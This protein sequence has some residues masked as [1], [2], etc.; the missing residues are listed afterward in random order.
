MS[1]RSSSCPIIYPNFTVRSPLL[2]L[3][4]T[5]VRVLMHNAQCSGSS[6]ASCPRRWRLRFRSR[7]KHSLRGSKNFIS[8]RRQSTMCAAIRQL[9]AI[10]TMKRKFGGSKQRMIIS[11]LNSTT[12]NWPSARCPPRN[13]DAA[14]APRPRRPPPKPC[15]LPR[16]PQEREP[17]RGPHARMTGMTTTRL[18]SRHPVP[19]RKGAKQGRRFYV[20]K[21]RLYILCIF[22]I[23]VI[24]CIS[25]IFCIFCVFCIFC[26]LVIFADTFCARRSLFMDFGTIS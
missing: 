15:L 20:P 9:V 2:F 14:G 5:R 13:N 21:Q 23:F 18:F 7:L 19:G 4:L 3:P 22:C 10:H 24:F 1:R 25:D 12:R 16:R 17:L 26:I 8:I 11:K 6:F